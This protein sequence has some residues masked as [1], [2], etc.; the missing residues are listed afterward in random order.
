LDDVAIGR[1]L[2][3]HV[4]NAARQDGM[5]VGLLGATPAGKPLYDATDWRTVEEWRLFVNA[6]SVQPA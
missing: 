6:T 2:L 1:A 3:G 4:L 5:S